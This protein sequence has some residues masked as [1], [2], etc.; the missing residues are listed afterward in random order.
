M[1]VAVGFEFRRNTGAELTV[2]EPQSG[3]Q[4]IG[5]R[6][7]RPFQSGLWQVSE[8]QAGEGSGIAMV[9]GISRPILNDV[10]ASTQ[11]QSLDIGE[12]M[13][14]EPLEGCSL[15]AI[16][17]DV[18]ECA[19]RMAVAAVDILSKLQAKIGCRP[20]HLF[21]AGP[22]AFAVL[23]GQ[24]LSNVGPIQCYDWSAGERQYVPTLQLA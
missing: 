5:P 16:D 8:L 2:I 11:A 14:F 24:Q 22:A 21:L 23:L 9:L 1:A 7:P 20:I 18:P 3:K 19:H 4:W 17:H 6:V 10:K 13:N 12:Y 15:A